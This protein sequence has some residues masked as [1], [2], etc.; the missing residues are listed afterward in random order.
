MRILRYF[1]GLMAL[2]LFNYSYAQDFSNKGKDFWVAYGLHCRMF[3]NNVGGT[4]EMVLYFATEAVTNVT[5]SIPGLGYTQTYSN[6]AANTI[7]TTSPLPKTGSQDARLTNEGITNKGIHIT[8]DKPIVAYAHI[9]NGNVSGATLLFPTNTLGK[10]YYS[11]NF[12]QHSNEGNS[13]SFVYAIATDTGTTT[14]EVL[15][16]A[17]TLSMNAGTTYTYNLTQ[18]QV[19][20]VMGVL[21]GNDG[22]DLTGSRIRSISTG[23]AGCKRIAV[24]SGSGKINIRCPLG[25][26]GSSADNFMVQAFPKNA[27]GKYYLTVPTSQMPNN[28]FRIAV[29]DPNTI[30]KLNGTP[31]TN[32]INGFYYQVGQT[33]LPNLIEADKPIMVAQYITSANQ[34]GNTA[35][36]GNGDPEVI[37]LS[38]VEQHI[39]RVILNSTP[40]FAIIPQQHYVNVVIK[41]SGSAISSFR[42]DGQ[43]PTSSFVTHPQNPAF[44]YLVQNVSAGQ[45]IVQS[46][47][48]FNAIAYGYGAA[49]SYGY[50]AGANV[51]DLYQFVSV[52]N[53]FATVDFAA[54]CK[55]S[56]F[57]FSATFPYQPTQIKWQFNGLFPDVTINAPTADSTWNV[58]GRQLYRY[59]LSTPYNISN[60]GTY[61]V[62]IVVQNPTPEGCSG[63]QE[64]NYELQV[65]ER[66]VADFNFNASGCVSDSVQFFDNANPDGRAIINYSWNFGDGGTSA[67]KNP[68]HLFSAAGSFPVKYSVITDIGCLSDTVTKTVVLTDPPLAK[69]GVSPI[70]CV[71]RSISFTDSSASV[72]GTIVKWTWNFGDGS[73]PVVATSN[74]SQVHTYST[75]GTFIVSLLVENSTGC[76]SVLF[77]KS[78][79]ISPNPVADFSFG[80][81]CLPQAAM[82]FTN[83]STI[84]DGSQ[85]QFLYQWTF[86][87]GGAYTVKDPL[88][89][90]SSTGPFTVSLAV[91]SNAGCVDSSI[92]TVNTVY[93]Q[94]QASFSVPAEACF[95]T[96]LNFT[97]QSVAPNSS[98]TQWNWNFG[99]GNSSSI[100]N[101]VHTYSS[102]GTYIVSLAVTSVIGCASTIATDTITIHALPQSNFTLSSPRCISQN[103]SFTDASVPNSGNIIKWTW[104]LGDGTVLVNN[105]NTTVTHNYAATGTYNVTLVTETDKGCTSSIFSSP[106]VISPLPQAGFTVPANCLTDPFSTFTDTSSISDGSQ[107]SFTYNWNFGDQNANGS[108]PNTSTV[109]NPTHK[110]TATGTYSVTLTVTSSNGCQATAVQPFTL[111][112]TVPQSVFTVNGGTDH[113]SNKVVAITNNSTVDVGNIV[114]LEIFWDDSNDPTNKTII[115]Y[116][117]PGAV[118]NHSYP[119]F[120]TPASKNYSIRVVAYSGDNCL[121]T[122]FQS[123]N[124]KATPLIV[125]DTIPGVCADAASFQVTQASVS[126]LTGTA[127]YSGNNISST[128]LF[129]PVT[130]GAGTH[131]VRYTFNADNGCSNFRER[132]ISV[133][134]VPTVNAG[135]DLFV[136]EGGSAVIAGSGS[137]IG[138]SYLWSPAAGLNNAAIAQPTVVPSNDITYTLTVTSSDGCI[139]SDAVVINV[140]K[141]PLIPNTFSPNG[142][143]IHD[144]WEIKY[145][146]SY[147]GATVEIFNRYGQLV[148]RSVGYPVP[149]DGKYKGNDLP[150]GTYYYIINPKNGRKQVSGFV[151][152]IR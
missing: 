124:L 103:I 118:Y 152:I 109:K 92:K 117:P 139:A 108:N 63:E 147:P 99:D 90:F 128:G 110:Y 77:T 129:D 88:H 61:P 33:A 15:P 68:A 74:A 42:I 149:W 55:N 106:V 137:G 87:D 116:P 37:Y 65:F 72:N 123:L 113:C 45:H 48:G 140:L 23:T 27:W 105:A 69:F 53:Q 84:T 151:D 14:V 19:L 20:N 98:V 16:S 115:N 119:E 125:F 130:A 9:Y 101:P 11:V 136:L 86:S 13:N 150:A 43:V 21:T 29:T 34:C 95:G 148:F 93:A 75:P 38:P 107:G 126:N 62:R 18:G 97:D 91:T 73:A 46:D 102:P 111:N 104:N 81:A 114:K 47:S 78:V 89:N 56:P 145:L 40:N 28:F 146:E 121:H 82:Q 144:R 49:E 51:K 50:N 100:K 132:T 134:P 60:T 64:V 96:A 57:Y 122:S 59:K 142:D 4:Q 25:P 133:F 39:N 22:V 79:I 6:I 36:A 26:N 24:F 131:T 31:L 44:S 2:L 127:F 141:M 54:A 83:T 8:S 70:T 7:F 35:I 76:K 41:N 3:Q 135:P 12:E 71:N 5:V 67:I 112:G 120:S 1:M 52:K 94:P 80:N 85:A 30:V 58:N 10:E 17:N 32:L 66:P 143:G 138:L